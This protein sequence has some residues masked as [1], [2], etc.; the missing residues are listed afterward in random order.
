MDTLLP[1]VHTQ[2]F[3]SSG[4]KGCG[5][6]LSSY[7]GL[8]DGRSYP[9]C[10]VA[11]LGLVCLWLVVSIGVLREWAAGFS[12]KL[13]TSIVLQQVGSFAR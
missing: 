9:G 13:C 8:L 5:V 4:W 2:L 10:G 7:L 11:V 6:L 1:L 12:S 3:F